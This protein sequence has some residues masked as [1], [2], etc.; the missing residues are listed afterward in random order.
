MYWPFS[1]TTPSQSE[2]FSVYCSLFSLLVCLDLSVPQH[3][4]KVKYFSVIVPCS[5]V[6]G[7]SVPTTPSQSEIFSVIVT[8]TLCSYV[9]AFQ[10]HNTLPKSQIG[11]K[12]FKL[13]PAAVS[14]LQELTLEDP[15]KCLCKPNFHRPLGLV[16]PGIF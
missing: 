8:C 9:L 14:T 4:P 10:Y 5:Y 15:I 12:V 3:P 7:L 1:A 16:S 2:I 13:W 6:L 11:G